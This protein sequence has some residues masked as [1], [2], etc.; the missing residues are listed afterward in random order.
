[1][2]PRVVCDRPEIALLYLARPGCKE[3]RGRL[4]GEHLWTGQQVGLHPLGDASE[5]GCASPG[6]VAHGA[7]I[8]LDPVATQRLHLAVERV[9]VGIFLDHDVGDKIL[10]RKTAG[11]HV[12][13]RGRLEHAIAA[14][15]ACHFRAH[16][17]DHA[18][19]HRDGVETL[20][21]ILVDHMQCATTARAFG[22][23]GQ[24]HDLDVREMC[25]QRSPLAIRHSASPL[26][27]CPG[28][29]I[30]GLL[31]E[32]KQLGTRDIKIVE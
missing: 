30:V 16:C 25:R 32:R 24:D 1:M 18:V 20:G 15:P 13:A 29:G 12:L 31:A 8:D 21:A 23:G 10:G 6:P 5:L 3:L 19:R 22:L 7:A 14:D 28:G 27:A 11:H 4:V 2:R 9:V 26:G 17:H